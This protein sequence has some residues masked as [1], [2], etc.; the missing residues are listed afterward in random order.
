MNKRKFIRKGISLTGTMSAIIGSYVPS[1]VG[2]SYTVDDY[3]IY[4]IAEFFGMD[5]F[6]N[7][8]KGYVKNWCISANCKEIKKFFEKSEERLFVKED[9]KSLGEVVK[10][11]ERTIDF[12]FGE[13]VKVNFV[14]RTS[15]EDP[16]SIEMHK[17]LLVE[18]NNVST[19]KFTSL[20]N[21]YIDNTS[22][23]RNLENMRFLSE[24]YK[25]FTEIGFVPISEDFYRGVVFF[26]VKGPKGSLESCSLKIK[27]NADNQIPA[28]LK[29]KYCDSSGYSHF[30]NL[31]FGG[32]RE[33]KTY[34][35][36]D[37]MK[38]IIDQIKKFYIENKSEN[39][40]KVDAEIANN[41][42]NNSSSI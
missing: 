20:N 37:E 30:Y 15:S 19:R 42:I 32:S 22:A 7:F 5:F 1:L 25:G 6:I 18:G 28:E 31:S 4:K 10:Y 40:K 36:I 13:K 3:K 38:K 35:T 21:D 16:S 9:T 26:E 12:N 41:I 8:V 17:Q 29:V 23:L 2:S 14:L 11:L 39:E 27:L 24:V 34:L 33:D